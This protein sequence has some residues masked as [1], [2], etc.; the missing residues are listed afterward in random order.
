M[1]QVSSSCVLS[2]LPQIPDH[3][4]E[5]FSFV[6]SMLKDEVSYSLMDDDCE[7]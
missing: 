2:S 3:E 5:Y 4:D 7:E 1:A 6:A